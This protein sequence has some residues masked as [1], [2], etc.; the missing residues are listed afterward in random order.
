MEEL[1]VASELMK[2]VSITEDRADSVVSGFKAGAGLS[3]MREYWNA[4]SARAK[5]R[6]VKRHWL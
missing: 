6:V 4:K 3:A 1:A 2:L 5:A